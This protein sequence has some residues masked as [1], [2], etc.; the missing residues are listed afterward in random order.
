[1]L[2]I[3]DETFEKEVLKSE[4]AVIVDC[5]AEWCAPC[6]IVGPRLEELSK[7]LTEVKFCKLDVDS[8]RV[9]SATYGIRAIPTMLVFKDGK[10][11]G[12]I[13]GALPKDMLKEK[14]NGFL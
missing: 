7:E 9:T 14:I 5:W 8:N 3:T 4:K 11:I 1:M 2:K 6:R 13:V 10:L 12:N